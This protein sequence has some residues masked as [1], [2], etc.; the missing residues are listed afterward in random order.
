MY[1]PT[2]HES[3]A[4]GGDAMV[5]VM[6]DN[7]VDPGARAVIDEAVERGALL[8]ADA[9]GH[10]RV[11]SREVAAL[12][13]SGAESAALLR[14][15]FAP[16]PGG[17]V[18]RAVGSINK[19]LHEQF[20]ARGSGLYAEAARWLGAKAPSIAAGFPQS[21]AALSPEHARV[22]VGAY[23]RSRTRR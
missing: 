6:Y 18:G 1:E 9:D 16:A 20:G 5:D 11:L 13:L 22:L 15:V 14:D 2:Q 19:A 8:P 10:A 23:L 12:R 3:T 17:D 7:T 4:P 21:A